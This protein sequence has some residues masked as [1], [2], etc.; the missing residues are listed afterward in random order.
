MAQFTLDNF[1]GKNQKVEI[2]DIAMNGAAGTRTIEVNFAGI[3]PTGARVSA[4]LTQVAATNL[5]ATCYTS[6]EVD[7]TGLVQ[8]QSRTI[9]AG[10][11]VVSDMTDTGPADTLNLQFDVTGARYFKVI[12]SAASAGASDIM[13]AQVSFS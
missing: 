7:G 3:R 8:V 12:F 5:V 13:D 6:H 4:Q 10:A 11:A 1:R 2:N 9:T